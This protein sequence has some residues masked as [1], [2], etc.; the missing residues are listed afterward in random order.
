MK[1][2]L[3]VMLLLTQ[4]GWTAGDDISGYASRHQPSLRV[5]LERAAFA[6]TQKPPRHILKWA[7]FCKKK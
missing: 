5:C 2:Y 3:V 7:W 1:T 6:N 4:E